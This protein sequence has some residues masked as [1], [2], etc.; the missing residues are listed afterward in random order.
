MTVIKSR[1]AIPQ[2]LQSPTQGVD[3]PLG[4]PPAPTDDY[5]YYAPCYAPA[6]D[7]RSFFDRA[8]FDHELTQRFIRIKDDWVIQGPQA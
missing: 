4:L 7:D 1:K 2:E 6:K 3:N 5:P 8:F